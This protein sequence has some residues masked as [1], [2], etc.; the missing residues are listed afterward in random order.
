MELKNSI[1]ADILKELQA[2]CCKMA[3]ERELSA[4]RVVMLMA[5][6]RH[7]VIVVLESRKAL[8][9]FKLTVPRA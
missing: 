3:I 2:L 8:A 5:A 4:E 1:F 7:D 6:Q 9:S